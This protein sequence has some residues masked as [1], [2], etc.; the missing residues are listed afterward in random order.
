MIEV[1][2]PQDIREFEP[3][4][5]GFL[6]TR[7]VVCGGLGLVGI[8]GIWAMEKSLGL[9]PMEVPLYL[10][11]AVPAGLI[12]WFKP[13]GI[14]FEKFMATA[15]VSNIIAPSKRVYKIDNYYTQ[16]EK[17]I[18]YAGMSEEEIAKAEKAESKK[19]ARRKKK[20]RYKLPQELRDYK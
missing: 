7:Q 2:V 16:M 10:I 15:F 12:G 6:T 8:Y 18:L 9:D 1:A 4:L 14:K 17:E 5:L 20:A 3:T 19:K 11:A 13:Y